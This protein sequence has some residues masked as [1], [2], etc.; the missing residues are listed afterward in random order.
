MLLIQN[1]S[2]QRKET[3]IAN[4][5]VEVEEKGKNGRNWKDEERELLIALYDYSGMQLMKTAWIGTKYGITRSKF[6]SLE[7]AL[8]QLKR[9]VF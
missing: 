7:Q 6:M 1:V 3:T 5:E 4:G 2:Q 9:E 8:W